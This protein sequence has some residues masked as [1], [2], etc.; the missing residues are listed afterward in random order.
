MKMASLILPTHDN[1]GVGLQDVHC[2]LQ[3]DLCDTF[4]GFTLTQGCGGYRFDSGEVKLESV[5]IYNIA[6]SDTPENASKLRTIAKHEASLAEQ[7]S[8]MITLPNGNVEF[9]R[10]SATFSGVAWSESSE[11]ESDNLR[12]IAA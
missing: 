11:L 4:G 3:S 9:I 2:A 12:R 7:E 8:V 6:M 5:V 10:A 1:H